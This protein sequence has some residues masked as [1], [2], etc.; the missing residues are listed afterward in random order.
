MPRQ[1]G[2]PAIL[3]SLLTVRNAFSSLSTSR[4]RPS[5]SPPTASQA[6]ESLNAT[7]DTSFTHASTSLAS[8]RAAMGCGGPDVEQIPEKQGMRFGRERRKRG[9]Q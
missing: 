3:E 5:N 2:D 9:C 8:T 6:S 7:S 4:L 1:K